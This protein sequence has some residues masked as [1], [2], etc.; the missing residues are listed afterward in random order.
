MNAPE[1]VP[2]LDSLVPQARRGI[3][4]PPGNDRYKTLEAPSTCPEEEVRWEREK[5]QPE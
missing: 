4:S 5:C 3:R 2:V 1:L